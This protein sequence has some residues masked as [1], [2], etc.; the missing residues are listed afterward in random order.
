MAAAV[1]K[2][3]RFIPKQCL[4]ADSKQFHTNFSHA[5]TAKMSSMHYSASMDKNDKKP[6]IISYY[7]EIK[8]EIDTLNQLV[9]AYVVK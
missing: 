9:H 4:Q 1:R 5:K 7:K 2:K 8:S 3:K 6:K